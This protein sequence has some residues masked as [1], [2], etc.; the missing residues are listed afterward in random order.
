MSQSSD[1]R[2]SGLGTPVVS[3]QRRR[4]P[5]NPR[6]P[7]RVG[8]APRFTVGLVIISMLVP[9]TATLPPALPAEAF[10]GP[11]GV[12]P[13]DGDGTSG[14]PY[15]IA[16]LEN[17]IWVREQTNNGEGGWSEGTY[18]L[19][20]ADIDL[21]SI[22]D[23]EPIG[24]GHP[25]VSAAPSQSFQGSYDGDNH[26]IRNL[27]ITDNDPYRG[28]FGY[29]WGATLENIRIE[30]AEVSAGRRSGIL[31]GASN[32]FSC[33]NALRTEISR[34]SVT[35]SIASDADRVGGSSATR[36]ATPSSPDGTS[37]SGRSPP[38]GMSAV[39][40]AGHRAIQSCP[41]RTHV[42]T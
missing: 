10:G 2:G 1:P 8:R 16:T 9:L 40:L 35:G 28:L 41:S 25:G 34:V 23:W 15:R 30:D 37:S 21:I 33:G 17:L 13:T 12:A 31:L 36:P 39:S 20:T 19:Q 18:F 32:C 29:V 6:R 22:D 26:T 7:V 4:D 14:D 3:R 5:S 24:I 27:K 38:K 42:R 11:E